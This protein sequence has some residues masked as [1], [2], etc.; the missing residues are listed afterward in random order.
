MR[1]RSICP[2]G[3]VVMKA[4]QEGCTQFIEPDTHSFIIKI[5]VDDKDEK[6]GGVIW[7][8]HITHV[9]SSQR[10]YFDDLSGLIAFLLPYLKAL[11]IKLPI[12][13]RVYQWLT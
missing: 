2:A 5:W 10:E 1:A 7:R 12:F 13:W 9:T 8:G 6:T 11:N 4:K 3:T